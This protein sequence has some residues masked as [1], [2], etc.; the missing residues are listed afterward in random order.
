MSDYKVTLEVKFGWKIFQLLG[1]VLVIGCFTFSM[2]RLIGISQYMGF[3][4]VFLI[5]LSTIFIMGMIYNTVYCFRHQV[6][7]DDSGMTQKGVINEKTVSYADICKLYFSNR[8][9]NS[10]NF[11]NLVGA[12]DTYIIDSKYTNFDKALAFLG[13]ILSSK[14]TQLEVG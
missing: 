6:T 8:L 14:D 12:S 2:K 5:V 3:G 9:W 4:G 7:F 1:S 11:I 10:G 13:A